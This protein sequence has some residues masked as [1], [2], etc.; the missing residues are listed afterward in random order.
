MMTTQE[1]IHKY[2][3]PAPRYTSYP[4][5]PLWN[6]E[7]MS[8]SEWMQIVKRSFVESNKSKGISVYIHLPFCESLC[9]YCGCNNRITKNNKV[10][11]GYID[12][13]LKEWQKYLDNFDEKPII[14]ELHLGGGTPTFFSPDNLQVLLKGI[15]KDVLIHPE[16]EFGFE[17]HPNNTTKVHLDV[18]HKLGFNRVSFG[19]QD[20]NLKIQQAINRIQ[21]F[22]NVQF[23]TEAARELQYDS[24]NFD[25]IYGLPFQTPDSIAYTIDKVGLLMPERIAFYSYAHVP[26]M[27]PGQRGYSEADLPD[28]EDKRKLYELGRQK[29]IALGYKDLGMDHFALPKDSLYKAA[30]RGTMHRNFMGYTVCNTDLLLGLGTSAISDAKYG[31]MQNKK[32]VEHYKEDV[33]NDK[34][35]IFKS[36]EM[37]EEDLLI[38]PAILQLLCTGR[39]NFSDKLQNILGENAK[40]QFLVMQKEGLLKLNDQELLVT[41]PGKAFIRN[42]A[43]VLDLRLS[44]REESSEPV[45][46]KAI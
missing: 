3:V 13:V 39:M 35:A 38:R 14:R 19:I 1:L 6:K 27:R 5:V 11:E 41:E 9:T 4:T 15:L 23:V 40:Q 46:S 44:R 22:K 16:H 36:H 43:M 24:V 26:W 34:M 28:N 31:Y 8:D 17:G 2:N 37:S 21:P 7:V 33:L 18:L 32:V 42:I 30:E 25:L 12:T 20:L 29:L 10:E 45:F